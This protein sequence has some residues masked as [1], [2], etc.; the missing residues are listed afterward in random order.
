MLI[1]PPCIA[2]I[3]IQI[4]GVTEALENNVR[5]F[6]SMT[7][8]AARDDLDE[9]TV[10]RL[11]RRIPTEV[12]KALEPLGYYSAAATHTLTH[13][14]KDWI[15]QIAIDPGRAVRISEATVE[16]TGAGVDDPALQAVVQR[17]D[18]HPGARLDHGVYESVKAELLR[19][20]INNGYLDAQLTRTDLIIDPTERRAM[21][22]LALES[23]PRYRF[24]AIDVE[25]PV[26]KESM[27]RKLLR[28]QSGDPYSLNAVLE[29]QYL[30]D[31]SQYFSAVEFEPGEPNRETHEVPLTVRAKKNKRN[32]YGIG[33]GYGTD[34]G[35]RG[36]FT[37]DNRY[38]NSLGHRSQLELIASSIVKSATARY[39]VPVGDVALEKFETVATGKKEELGALLSRRVELEFGLTQAMSTWQRVLFVRLSEEN[40]ELLNPDTDPTTATTVT[41]NTNTLAILGKQFLIIPGISIATLPPSLLERS[42]RRYSVYAELTGSPKSF[43]S[44]VSF[45][46]LRTS[47]EKV[48]DIAPLWRGRLRGQVGITWTSDFDFMPAS[49]RFFAGGDNSVRGFGLNELS[50]VDDKNRRVGGRHLL[51]ASAELER[52]IPNRWFGNNLGAAVFVDGGNAINNF[53]DPLEYST[54]IGL[55]YRLA[56]VASIGV[57]VAQALSENRSPRLHLRLATLF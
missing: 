20:A 24:G 11:G 15:V 12:R 1:A 50:P 35:P 33:G 13:D 44:D 6:L 34:T 16:I 52:D 19:T 54:G 3:D 47:A 2:S 9:E 42:Q 17:G 40:N 45:L 25:Q 29:S 38:L 5:A 41:T 7:R 37:W 56:G 14:N 23:G 27:A 22:H 51:V 18:L 46:Q 31:D 49:H 32:R 57:D 43:G 8:Y 36:K 48:F 28:M 26:L 39:I 55:R 4:S 30:F 53:N 10:A 21:V